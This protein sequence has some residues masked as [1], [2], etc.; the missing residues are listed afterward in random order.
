MV[1]KNKKRKKS[2]PQKIHTVLLYEHAHSR[3]QIKCRSVSTHKF[4][5]VQSTYATNLIN[6][7]KFGPSLSRYSS[8]SSVE[9]PQSSGWLFWP[10]TVL[11]LVLHFDCWVN[12]WMTDG[13]GPWI[14]GRKPVQIF[15]RAHTHTQSTTLWECNR[16]RLRTT[17]R[18]EV[19]GFGIMQ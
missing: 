6:S 17:P 3:W 16:F 7:K 15:P 12:E 13:N 4:Y 18:Y 11:L 1:L 14:S 8:S 19:I 2:N 5:S 10:I 9:C